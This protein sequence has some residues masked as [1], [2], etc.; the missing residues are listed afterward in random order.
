[1]DLADEII[2]RT[3]FLVLSHY[4]R[5]YRECVRQA[6]RE[7]MTDEA[8]HKISQWYGDIS[9]YDYATDMCGV[10]DRFVKARIN[11]LWK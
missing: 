10:Y 3:H 8:L 9:E 7:L 4:P 6:V 2:A 1:M 5:D 11:S